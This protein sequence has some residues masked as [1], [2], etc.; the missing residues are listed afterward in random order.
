MHPHTSFA[1]LQKIFLCV[2]TVGLLV[3][4][5]MT[6]KFGSSMSWLHAIALVTV[7]IAAAFIFPFRAFVLKMGHQGAARSL[8]ALGVFFVGLEFFSHLGYT[9]G[10][11]ERS[12]IEATAQ[13]A[14]YRN[15]QENLASEKSNLELWKQHL[16]KLQAENPWVAAVSADGLKAQV[17]AHTKAIELEE[18]RGGCKS[19]CLARMKEKA[20]LEERIGIAEQSNKLAEQIEATQRIVDKKTEV[21][22][23][24]KVGFSP[25]KAQTDFVGQIYLAMT[26]TEG[27]K[28]LSPDSVT[29][30]FTQIFIGFFIAL[31]ATFLPTTAMYM[32]FF[33]HKPPAEEADEA[34]VAAPV[35]RA[36]A[37][38]IAKPRSYES[39]LDKSPELRALRMA[40][41]A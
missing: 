21:A 27:E 15:E 30:S 14:S 12:N 40:A 2:G 5:A 19:K 22:T 37:P 31:G 7:T 28:A 23:Q 34:P 39:L 1:T 26:G 25:V 20:A 16:A 13:N 33:G 6:Y 29:L 9:I 4:V 36:P 38:A 11:R 18:A 3:S 35:A 8:M 10:M 41:A 24:S 32:A 17:A